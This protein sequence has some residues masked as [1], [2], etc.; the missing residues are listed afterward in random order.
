MNDFTHTPVMLRE[1]LEGLAARPGGRWLDATCG[2]GGHSAAILAAT[3]PDGFLWACDQDGD[4]LEA[5]GRRLAVYPGRFELRRMNFEGI[6]GWI[7]PGSL[8]GVCMDLGASSYQFDTASRGFSFQSDGPLDMRMDTRGG[9]TAAD[10]VNGWSA[11]EMA[12]LFRELGDEK[13]AGRIA[14]RIVKERG[15]RRFERTL[16]L[17]QTIA[18]E[19]PRPWQRTHPATQCFQA[20]RMAVNRELEVLGAGLAGAWRALGPG[21]RLAVITFHSGEDRVVKAFMREQA[22][23]YDVPAGQPD[24]PELRVA[25]RPR[26]RL[27]HRRPLRACEA[28]LAANP[29]S[30]SAQLRVAEKM[31]D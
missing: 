4:A 13:D 10:I 24:V 30:R 21:G 18:D 16:G 25:R 31:E 14:R 9:M 29:R 15:V 2:G 22:R 17:A 6:G 8:N 19:C 27:V 12:R 28:E 20:L 23:D 7:P 5:A 1:V 26:G 3:A 11:E